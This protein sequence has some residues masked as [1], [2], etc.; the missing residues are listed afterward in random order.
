MSHITEKFC[1]TYFHAKLIKL[2]IFMK[3]NIGSMAYRRVKITIFASKIKS[4]PQ[5]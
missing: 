1:N 3:Q 4:S 5:E 2:L